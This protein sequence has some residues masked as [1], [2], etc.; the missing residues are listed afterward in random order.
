[1]PLAPPG[2][3]PSGRG[4]FPRAARPNRPPSRRGGPGSSN[5][6]PGRSRAPRSKPSL[7]SGRIC[8]SRCPARTRYGCSWS[9]PRTGDQTNERF[10]HEFVGL[11]ARQKAPCCSRR[12]TIASRSAGSIAGTSE[13]PVANRAAG[14]R[15]Q[16][17]WVPWSNLRV[18]GCGGAQKKRREVR[19]ARPALQSLRPRC[20]P[21]AVAASG[22]PLGIGCSFRVPSPTKYRSYWFC[23]PTLP[24]AISSASWFSLAGPR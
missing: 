18:G 23:D 24:L 9:R 5:A 11:N 19:G 20:S 3:K 17:A 2:H 14:G 16:V 21:R 12:S 8:G 15:Q 10:R 7:P 6:G 1:M 13:H 4:T 22:R